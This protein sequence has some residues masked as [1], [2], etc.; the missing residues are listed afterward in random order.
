VFG[1]FFGDD[2]QEKYWADEVVV[3]VK[4]I[5]HDDSLQGNYFRGTSLPVL[6]VYAAADYDGSP[7]TAF[8]TGGNRIA[9]LNNNALVRPRAEFNKAFHFS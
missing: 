3:E 6:H 7:Y 9:T 8:F 1:F 5:D 4:D 2:T